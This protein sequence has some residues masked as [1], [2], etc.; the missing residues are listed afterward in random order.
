M[1]QI[2]NELSAITGQT[3]NEIMGE[4]NKKIKAAKIAKLNKELLKYLQGNKTDE[5]K[6]EKPRRLKKVKIVIPDAQ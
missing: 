3:P 4:A 6:E 1:E 2:V 5:I